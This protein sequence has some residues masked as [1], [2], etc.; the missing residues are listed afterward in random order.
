MTDLT[1]L[2]QGLFTTFLPESKQGDEAWRE[3]HK[4]CPNGK[5]L[6][7]HLKS[8]LSQ[9]RKAGYIVKKA[10]KSKKTLGDIF[11]EMDQLFNELSI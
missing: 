7:I 10:K 11:K 5:V 9:L 8:T 4:Q 1:Y 6:T 2:E 3:I